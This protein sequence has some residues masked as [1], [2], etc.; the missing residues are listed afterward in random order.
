M[1][2]KLRIDK[3]SFGRMTVGGRDFD[4]DLILHPDGRI[5]EDWRRIQGHNLVPD[6]ITSLLE[7]APGKLIIGTG[8]SGMMRVSDDVLKLCKNRGIEVVV[9]RT[10]SAVTKF[11]EAVEADTVVAACFHLTC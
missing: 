10:A 4:S 8:I 11:N 3:Y 9:C 5:Q 1:I 6:D 2:M 7:E